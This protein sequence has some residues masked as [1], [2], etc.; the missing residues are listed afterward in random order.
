MPKSHSDGAGKP[1]CQPATKPPGVISLQEL[2]TLE[3]AKAR[4]GWTNSALRAA[5]ARGRPPKRIQAP[6]AVPARSRFPG[7]LPLV[8][9]GGPCE[10][11]LT[12]TDF[13][14]VDR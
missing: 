3:E 13:G 6:V 11:F 2:Y 12:V 5:K 8:V 14:G 4:L 10:V 7:V 9:H 1:Y